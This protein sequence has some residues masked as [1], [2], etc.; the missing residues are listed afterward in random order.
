MKLF[1]CDTET[2]G[3]SSNAAIIQFAGIYIDSQTKDEERINF[4]MKPHEGA[5]ISDKALE[6]NKMLRDQILRFPDYH[7]TYS[8]IIKFFDSKVDKFDKADKMHF[9]AWNG[10]FD[11]QKFYELSLRC[12]NKYA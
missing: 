2:T 1:F 4:F 12:G 5:E 11:W 6:V 10:I 3:V 7:K 8:D 9:V